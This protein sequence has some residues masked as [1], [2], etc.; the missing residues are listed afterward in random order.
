MIFITRSMTILRG[1]RDCMY[2]FQ[3]LSKHLEVSL[4]P[5]TADLAIRIGLHSGPVT[6]GVLRGEQARFQLFGDTMNTAS[7]MESTSHPHKIQISQETADLL[8]EANKGHWCHKRMDL[9]E[10]KGKGV[11]QTYWL[12]ISGASG[13]SKGSNNNKTESQGSSEQSDHGP[14]NQGAHMQTTPIYDWVKLTSDEELREKKAR[15]VRWNVEILTNLLVQVQERRHSIGT[16]ADSPD[17]INRLEK[18]IARSK[19]M[20]LEEVDES[21]PGPMS[22]KSSFSSSYKS[23]PPLSL[24]PQKEQKFQGGELT[25]PVK[26]QLQDYVEQVASLYRN[27]AFHNFEHASHV[28]MSTVKLFSRVV[29]PSSSAVAAINH[30][31]DIISDPMTQFAYKSHHLCKHKFFLCM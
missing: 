8:N 2:R 20:V 3:A 24:H 19:R 9:V 1:A 13:S 11:L 23:T 27:H 5:D 15:L 12:H 31:Y 18:S 17:K 6:A 7:R 28:A 16:K 30:M 4:G 26:E 14:D 10:A 25:L 21:I 22:N 29:A